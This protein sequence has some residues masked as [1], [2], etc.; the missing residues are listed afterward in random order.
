MVRGSALLLVLI[1]GLASSACAKKSGNVTESR[2][3]LRA[4]ID[5][6]CS[7]DALRELRVIALGDFPT[8]DQTV[9][10][11]N[12]EGM[13]V[14][15]ETFPLTTRAFRVE[16]DT[17][18]AS[19]R[20][21][22]ASET[23]EM[24]LLPRGRTCRASDEAIVGLVGASTFAAPD[25][26][27]LAVGGLI[28][29]SAQRSV[30]RVRPG[31]PR[32]E[33]L[34][35]NDALFSKRAFASVTL[36]DDLAVVIGG[37][38]E[39]GNNP[40]DSIEVYDLQTGRFDREL[41]PTMFLQEGRSH[42]AAIA[43]VDGRIL[44]TGGQGSSGL[45]ASSEVLDVRTGDVERNANSLPTPRRDATLVRL[46]D[47]S[48]LAI[49]GEVDESGGGIRALGEVLLF[50]MASN[51]FQPL[52]DHVEFAPRVGAAVL[53]LLGDRVAYLGGADES[54]DFVDAVDVLFVDGVPHIARASVTNASCD[55]GT[56]CRSLRDLRASALADGRILVTG[57]DTGVGTSHLYLLDLNRGT[58]TEQSLLSPVLALATSADGTTALFTRGGIF[59]RR[60]TSSSRF[61]NPSTLVAGSLEGLALDDRSHWN[62]IGANLVAN[63]DARVDV[64]EL[65]YL[66]VDVE[67]ESDGDVEVLLL[68]A[69]DVET[70]SVRTDE[71][72][73]ALC[74]AARM[75]N[76]TS[77]IERRGDSLT[78]FGGGDPVTCSSSGGLGE[79]VRIALRARA[80]SSL[81]ALR[82][83]RQA[84]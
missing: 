45:L 25:G 80:G 52:S 84:Q 32:P 14:S 79:R 27:M 9:G 16:S 46:D 19:V 44:V 11:V 71:V 49:G 57:V 21:P 15:F 31:A 64:A 61:D 7:A 81:E 63:T 33:L 77:R 53:P 10:I 66:H 6:A 82:L 26:S 65:S 24:L 73:F 37:E 72:G 39:V 51:A 3:V 34:E 41:L 75:P 23:N 18:F 13:A 74:H 56:F 59:V 12:A 2:L 28:D 40:E 1:L 60:D 70:I 62:M 83:L 48:V 20:F 22:A 68:G 4:S 5:P 50:D 76:A 58:A 29:A 78:F 17:F 67:L 38:A 54:G 42:H 69:G 43:L 35:V 55:G 36:S 8:T 30:V 47:G